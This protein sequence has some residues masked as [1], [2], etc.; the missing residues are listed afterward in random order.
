MSA[1]LVRRCSGSRGVFVRGRWARSA[2]HCRGRERDARGG[3]GPSDV[4]PSVFA[5]FRARLEQ[6]AVKAGDLLLQISG[7]EC[8]GLAPDDAAALLR[9]TEN[10]KVGIVAERPASGGAAGEKLDLIVTRRKFKVEGVIPR[11]ATVNGRKIGIV[12]IKSFSSNTAG[13]VKA[14]VERF[15]SSGVSRIVVDLRGNVGGLLPGGID[16]AGLFLDSGKDVVFIIRKNGSVEGR[17][18]LEAGPQ[19]QGLPLTLLVDKGTASAAEVF[20]A[21]VRENDRA[22]LVGERTFGK[23]VIQTVEPLTNGGGVAVTV[24]RYE[25]PLHH[26]INKVGIPVDKEIE[27]PASRDAAECDI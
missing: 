4:A 12:R 22:M 18:T 16:T 25:T 2:T 11:E 26:N 1:V 3:G 5:E 10:T 21:A 23:G 6:R 7:D 14:A 19:A 9:G 24:A 20:A 13:D 15:K 17:T 27:C 8:R